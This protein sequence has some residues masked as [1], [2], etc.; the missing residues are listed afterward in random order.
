MNVLITQQ[1]N[2]NMQKLAKSPQSEVVT[3]FNFAS[4]ATK[5]D[6]VNSPYVTNIVSNDDN[7][8]TIRA[9][10]V[11][12]FCSFNLDTDELLFLDVNEVT[13]INSQSKKSVDY[14]DLTLFDCNGKPTAY[15]SDQKERVIYT[16][17]GMPMA[18]IDEQEN[19][20]GFNGVHLG[21][22]EDDIIWEH[23][24]S[25]V[26]F[27]KDTCPVFRQFEPFKGFK[28]FKPFKVYTQY[29]PYKPCRAYDNSSIPLE[30]FLGGGR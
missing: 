1:F 24:G 27:T 26:G 13:S 16:F 21:W 5:E 11:R 14:S 6:I 22:F 17:S 18:Y 15:I 2:I 3:L 30:S 19:I 8:F 20:Y 28:Q 12:I 23:S 10:S 9:G 25:R 29:A 7:I 4:A